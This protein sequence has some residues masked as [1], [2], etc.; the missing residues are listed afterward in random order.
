MRSTQTDSI[1]NRDGTGRKG[2]RVLFSRRANPADGP[3][4]GEKTWKTR[5]DLS[6]ACKTRDRYF[7][8]D[9]NG[10]EGDR[11][12]ERDA[13]GCSLGRSGAPFSRFSIG[14]ADVPA[15]HA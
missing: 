5:V 2:T 4:Y 11:P 15:S 14:G 9:A 12:S 3:R 7:D 1:G 8:R 13:R 10:D 6:V